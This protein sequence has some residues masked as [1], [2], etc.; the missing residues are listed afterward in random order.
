MALTLLPESNIVMLAFSQP[1]FLGL[2]G[3]D[4][5]RLQSLCGD[6]YRLINNDPL[7]GKV[8]SSLPYC[9]S[10]RKPTN[11]LA[12]I[13]RPAKCDS[14]TPCLLFLHGYGGSFLWYQHLLAESFP[15]YL[16]LCPAYGISAA[17]VPSA[18]IRQCIT[19]SE[20]ELGHPIRRPHLVGL[21]AGGFGAV[22][23]YT[24]M[25]DAF[26]RAV[27]LGAYAPEDSLQRLTKRMSMYFLVGAR[28]SYV[29][30]AAFRKQMDSI[31]PKVGTLEFNVLPESDHYFLL[32]QREQAVKVLQ[33]W[34][35]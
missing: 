7:F 18:L 1:G 27:V 23:V 17:T 14:N 11:G 16:I 25:P 24:T 31:R 12:V 35:K 10:E 19:A 3:E 9:Y 33:K 6:R 34:L 15:D 5:G 30:S 20:H 32:T 22:R 26:S 21:S 29:Q 4:A 28:E 8:P 2:S 13:Y